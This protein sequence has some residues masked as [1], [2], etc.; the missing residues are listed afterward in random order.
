MKWKKIITGIGVVMIGATMIGCAGPIQTG[1]TEA[2][3]V[4]AKQIGYENGWENGKNSVDITSDNV[5]VIGKETSP[6][7]KEIANLKAEKSNLQIAIEDEINTN[8]IIL[9][10]IFDNDGNVEY[11]VDDLDDDEVSEIVDRI[12]FINDAKMLAAEEVKDELADE[13]DGEEFTLN[14]NNTIE[15]DEDDIERIRVK[16]DDDEIFIEN[17]DF[18]DR[19]TDVIVTAKF[20]QDDIDFE[21]DFKVEIEDNKVDDIEILEIR[22]E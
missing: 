5:E 7:L 20:E 13:L 9:D 12:V 15:F 2:E 4:N 1:I 16:D 19:D 21:V 3:L 17:F 22:E 10:H 6:L 14:N 11:L 18:K 8:G